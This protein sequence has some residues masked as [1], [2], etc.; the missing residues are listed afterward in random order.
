MDSNMIYEITEWINDQE[1][2]SISTSQYWND[3]TEEEKKKWSIPN[4]DFF[5]FEEYF[6]KKGLFKQ[7]V[8]ILEQNGIDLNNSTVAS[9]ASGTCAL[10]SSI[11]KKYQGIKKMFC[12]EFSKYRIKE[13]APRVL[14]HYKIDPNI[15]ELCLGSFYD[16]KI[17]DNSLDIVILCQ[18]FHH[19]EYPDKLLREIRRVLKQNGKILIIGEHY[20]HIL[21][22]SKRVIKH[23]IKWIINYK[24]ARTKSEFLPCWQYLFPPSKVKG[25][26]HYS[27]S[28]YRRIFSNNSFKH[29]QYVFKDIKNQAFLL[30]H[31]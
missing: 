31:L 16:L 26:I 24:E 20:F 14:N 19:A 8:F 11:L 21:E 5:S 28:Q 23:F 18:A 3:K 30:N 1:I 10:E 15:I 9:L 29:K 7:F 17:E 22:I 27:K 2:E 13:I 6:D 4:D 12:V 25:D